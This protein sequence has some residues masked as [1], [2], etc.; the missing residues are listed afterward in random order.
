MKFVDTIIM[1]NYQKDKIVKRQLNK[2]IVIHIIN[3]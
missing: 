1:A 2:K 3:L